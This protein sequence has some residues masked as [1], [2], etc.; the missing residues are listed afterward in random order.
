MSLVIVH[1][2]DIH[3]TDQNDRVLTKAEQISNAIRS[4]VHTNDDII[5]AVTG[6]IA[7]S[8]K[9]SEYEL[10]SSF[11]DEITQL[12]KKDTNIT[13]HIVTIPGNHDCSLIPESQTRTILINSITN[14]RKEVIT[15]EVL[16]NILAAQKN[17]RE[18][19]SQGLTVPSLV[20]PLISYYDLNL[21]WGRILLTGYN[22]A[23]MSQLHEKEGSLYFPQEELTLKE[24]SQ[25]RLKISLA[26]HPLNWFDQASAN[27]LRDFIRQ[28]TDI[29]LWGH[30]HRKDILQSKSY[31][32]SLFEANGK[33][34]QESPKS[35]TSAF[36]IYTIDDTCET[37]CSAVF[38]WDTRQH[39]Y[40]E[41]KNQ[42][43]PFHK[44][45][46]S[47]YYEVS[48]NTQTSEYMNDYGTLI[49]HFALDH[50][51]LSDLFCW[52]ELIAV[53][54][55]KEQKGYISYNDQ[56]QIINLCKTSK[57][58]LINGGL[59]SGK[60][61]L[62]K[63]LY[64][65]I[66]GEKEVCV[67]VKGL[68]LKA[69]PSQ[70]NDKIDQ[71]YISQYSAESIDQFHQLSKEHKYLIID[72][73]EQI[74]QVN[75]N[76]LS[77]TDLCDQFGH[78]I[79][80]SG[81]EISISTLLANQ[82]FPNE[83]K[84]PSYRIRYFGNVKRDELIKK[85]YLLG[86]YNYGSGEYETKVEGA[87]SIINSLIGGY[88]A[89]VPSNPIT[90]VGI[91]QS[92]NAA[93]GKSHLRSSQFGYLYDDLVHNAL[94]QITNEEDGTV[95]IYIAMLSEIAYKMYLN[96]SFFLSDVSIVETITDYTKKKIVP[97]DVLKAISNL[98]AVN[99]L[100][101]NKDGLYCFKY[102]YLY[103][104][105]VAQYIAK[106]IDEKDIKHQIS[107]MSEKL[108]IEAYGNII[109]FVCHFS[110]SQTIIENILLKAYCTF[111][112]KQPLDLK[113][114]GKFLSEAY[115]N[116][117]RVLTDK[118]VGTEKDVS[119][120]RQQ[121][122]LER[123]K[124]EQTMVVSEADDQWQNDDINS[125]VADII[126]ALKTID[127]L[128]QILKNY[129]GDI[130][131]ELKNEVILSIDS[132]SMRILKA[133]I[134]IFNGADEQYIRDCAKRLSKED[135]NIPTSLLVQEVQTFFSLLILNFSNGL[136]SRVAYSVQSKYLI[137]ATEGLIQSEQGSLSL[138]LALW[139]VKL[140]CQET[141]DYDGLI[142]FNKMLTKQKYDVASKNLRSIVISHLRHR[143]CGHQDRDKLCSAFNLTKALTMPNNQ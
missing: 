100:Q 2:T 11:F 90:I 3:I 49:R 132:L 8:G 123:D 138:E 120:L 53:D 43:I 111:D 1:I 114:P 41:E 29:M 70:I 108:Y 20:N 66:T 82:L 83:I 63:M 18:F 119:L 7:Y 73:F 30:E 10:A 64:L 48:P 72:D 139:K 39:L 140:L 85:W 54:E 130:D 14:T 12:I 68:D 6:D 15:Q 32:W 107:N 4:T 26:H 19:N 31:K 122:L 124:E 129:P 118:A 59:L 57:I 22:T 40:K 104:Y 37:I 44:N 121:D 115:D 52:P 17:F 24:E 98:A 28:N 56:Q 142:R 101:K 76:N 97:I 16:D 141:P 125:E 112:N 61:A 110:Q 46:A 99:I 134:D 116:V 102:P 103:Y 27:L 109:V 58:L 106:H 62:G 36:A 94:N 71:Q 143:H 89:F 81:S 135:T 75:R 86:N 5:I 69:L 133:V 88:H 25:Y 77:F 79:L 131:G 92:I 51:T 33:E 128:G 65:S 126:S 84:I 137:A 113:E 13:P 38:T 42:T 87:T 96:K 95:N 67:F 80:L 60:T 55:M 117:R 50:I 34:L 45:Y 23:W 47:I 78:I 35:E 21:Q 93:N 127:V 74:N 136:I 9:K 105:F 91:L